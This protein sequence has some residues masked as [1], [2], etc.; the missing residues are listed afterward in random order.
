MTTA[1]LSREPRLPRLREFGWSVTTIM[2]KELRS[3]FR[4]RRAFVIIT[5]YL[6][7]LALIAYGV[8]AV[9]APQAQ[10]QAQ[11][12]GG[13]FANASATIG[14]AIFLL[15]SIFQMLL[16]GFIAPAFTSGAISLERE[17]QTLDLL[18]TTPM[19]PGGIIVGKLLAALAFVGL[20]IVAAI[21]ISGL[22][23]MYGG[24]AIDDIVRQQVVLLVTALGLGAIGLFWSA[25]IKR[26]QAAT[27]LTYVTVLG[28]VVG[29]AMIFIFWSIV[30][31]RDAD[32][33][34]GTP[35]LAPE[36]LLWV[37]PAVAMMDVV[38]NTE[39][40]GFGAFSSLMSTLQGGGSSGVV[41]DGDTC[42]QADGSGFVSGPVGAGGVVV[43]LDCP[44]NARCGVAGDDLAVFQPQ[45]VSGH[46]WTRF[47][48]SFAG[49]SLL[50]TLA[51]MRLVVPAPMR[52]VFRR[53]RPAKAMREAI[54]PAEAD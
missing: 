29:T 38:A 53:R 37:N 25:L 3:R 47:V 10:M 28:L 7:V 50:L 24:A 44:P 54:P 18:V 5:V 36:Q 23:L 39:L 20:M 19:R 22:V 11:F 1:T 14:Q 13:G 40:G 21:P 33:Q 31:T 8:Y 2:V 49:I 46:F 48:V 4:G 43:P 34:F 26:T 17:K 16:V 12:G 45:P 41:C 51:S 42:F 15:L 32:N 27:V 9:V 52:F 30:S 35:R 6:G